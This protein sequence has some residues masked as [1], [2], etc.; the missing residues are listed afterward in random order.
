MQKSSVARDGYEATTSQKLAREIMGANFFGVEEA[1]KHFG[2]KPTKQQLAKLAEIPFTAD[3][4]RECK[5]THVLVA[6][7]PLSVLDMVKMDSSLFSLLTHR[8]C[9]RE[10]FAKE[11]GALGWQLVRKTHVRDSTWKGWEEQ[12][13]LLGKDEEVPS[14]Q[15]MVFTIIGHY[16]NTGE[17]L[18]ENVYVRC[19]CVD[20]GGYRVYVGDFDSDGLNVFYYRLLLL[21]GR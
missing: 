11:K 20:S 16:K 4:L 1:V 5:D 2:V 13:A 21:L 6:V 18:F 14:A 17:R 8:W 15:V 7:F 3:V 12:Q 19:S 9:G 10:E